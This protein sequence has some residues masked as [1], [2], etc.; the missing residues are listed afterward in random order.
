M[1]T[2][3]GRN[4]EAIELSHRVTEIDPNFHQIYGTVIS[5]N[6]KLGN[7]E[8]ALNAYEKMKEI[9][10]DWNPWSEAQLGYIYAVSGE[11]DKAHE[12]LDILLEKKNDVYAP[13]LRKAYVASGL[14]GDNRVE[15]A[16]MDLEKRIELDFVPAL[17]I[18]LVYLGLGENL[19]VFEW[20]DKA[21]E[22]RDIMIMFVR[23]IPEL[24]KIRK[25]ERFKAL[26]EKMS[27][28]D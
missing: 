11:K 6:C 12:I 19:K 5:L 7:Y 8:E 9:T 1:Y 16:L 24:E 21:Y 15:K 4:D 26:I 13:V 20:L 27:L 14:A 10:G 25:D 2:A 22:E 28:S 17:S 18:A 3:L 23:M